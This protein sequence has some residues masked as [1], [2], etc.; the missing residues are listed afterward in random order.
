M[1]THAKLA[2]KKLGI[3]KHLRPFFSPSQLH[4]PYRGLIRL[5]VEVWCLCIGGFNSHSFTKQGGV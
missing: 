4:A 2:F 1:S 5:P 3:L